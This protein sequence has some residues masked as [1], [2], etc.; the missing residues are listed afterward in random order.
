MVEVGKADVQRVLAMGETT[1]FAYLQE[2]QS[3]QSLHKQF[4]NFNDYYH[5]QV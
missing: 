1:G 3:N 2:W 4:S 5:S